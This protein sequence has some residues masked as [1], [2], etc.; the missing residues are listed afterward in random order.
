MQ[1]LIKLS[2]GS[3]HYPQK[4]CHSKLTFQET[5]SPA[6]EIKNHPLALPKILQIAPAQTTFVTA[7]ILGKDLLEMLRSEATLV[8]V[9][10]TVTAMLVLVEPSKVDTEGRV[11]EYGRRCWIRK[12][13]MDDVGDEQGQCCAP[14]VVTAASV[15]IPW[16][17]NAVVVT[18]PVVD[19]LLYDLWWSVRYNSKR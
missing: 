12:S 15:G 1:S 6:K 14:A 16:P 10:H 13:D 11:G 8:V 4:S 19:V 2:P 7:V 3:Q 5:S 17:D 9:G 18:V